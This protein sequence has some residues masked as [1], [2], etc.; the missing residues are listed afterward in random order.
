MY[1]SVTEWIR[2]VSQLTFVHRSSQL[3]I[4]IAPPLEG[5]LLNSIQILQ[6]IVEL[7]GRERQ[8]IWVFRGSL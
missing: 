2:G 3:R 8:A 1:L 7:E 5:D 6:K 4:V